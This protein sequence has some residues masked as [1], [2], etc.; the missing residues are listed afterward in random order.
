[1]NHAM[2][3]GNLSSLVV[4]SVLGLITKSDAPANTRNGELRRE[5]DEL[6][7][8]LRVQGDALGEIRQLLRAMA[9]NQQTRPP[10][11]EIPTEMENIGGQANLRNS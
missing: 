11:A 7:D 6:R 5:V 4:Q 9:D 8:Q 1:M 3:R 10:A 2:E